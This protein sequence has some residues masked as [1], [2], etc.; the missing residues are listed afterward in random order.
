MSKSI[1]IIGVVVVVLVGAGAMWYFQQ[2]QPSA[3]APLPGMRIITYSDNGYS[4][5]KLTIKKGDT[6]TF[7]NESSRVTW[8]ATDIHPQHKVY[9]GSDIQKC[10]DGSDKSMLFDSCG[11]VQPGGEWSFTFREAGMWRYHDHK[12]P[13]ET[14][15]LIVEE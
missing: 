8:P 3:P 7:K 11:D 13:T 5:E 9:P 14:G 10:F 2:P 12:R 4:P 1:F 6:V 15:T